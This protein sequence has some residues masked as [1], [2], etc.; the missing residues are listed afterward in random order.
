MS[1]VGSTNTGTQKISEAFTTWAKNPIFIDAQVKVKDDHVAISACDPGTKVKHSLPTTDDTSQI[2]WRSSDMAFIM[3]SEENTDAEC[4]STGL[5][6]EFLVEE[7]STNEEVVTRY[8]E[9][10]EECSLR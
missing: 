1:V 2:F 10:L 6:T 4:V 7:I 5:Y 9:L 3:R 8:G